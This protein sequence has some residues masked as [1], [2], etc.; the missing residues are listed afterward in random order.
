MSIRGI[1]C[2]KTNTFVYYAEKNNIGKNFGIFSTLA[3][4][5]EALS[6]LLSGV[7]AIFS[8][9]FSFVTLTFLI[10]LTGSTCLALLAKEKSVDETTL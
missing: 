8:I 9:V 4:T 2:R 7:I 1:V 6:S 10:V 5:S 3:N